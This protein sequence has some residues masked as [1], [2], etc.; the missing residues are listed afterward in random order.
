MI[1]LRP[2]LP[3]PAL[4]R[5][6]LLRPLLSRSIVLALTLA[7]FTPAAAAADYLPSFEQVQR[8]LRD[9]PELAAARAERD[10]AAHDADA[11]RHGPHEFETSVTPQQRRSAGNERFDEWEVQLSRP[12]RLPGKAALDGRIAAQMRDVAEQ[13]FL[14][15]RLAV[16]ETLLTQ[17]LQWL[18]AEHALRLLDTQQRLLERER[19]SVQVMHDKGSAATLDLDL[20]NADLASARARL[21]GAKADARQARQRLAKH[22]PQLLPPERAPDLADPR[23]AP[24][25][26][27]ALQQAL[28]GISA[29]LAV[30]RGQAAGQALTADRAN[31]ERRPD[32][33]LGLRWLRE[34]RDPEN[35]LG[36]V[37]SVPIGGGYRRAQAQAEA[38]REAAMHAQAQGVERDVELQAWEAIHLARSLQ[39]RWEAENAALAAHRSAADRSRRAWELGELGLGQYLIAERSLLDRQ[40][41]EHEA[42]M[43]ALTAALRVQLQ[44]GRLWRDPPAQP[45]G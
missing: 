21:I 34:G 6:A 24:E 38:A 39:T 20:I 35:A 23:P 25:D 18:A 43:A 9:H 16:Q 42:R 30:A 44:A 37:V 10:A 14:G 19:H 36:L 33:T 32:P 22:F 5:S 31:A 2:P 41:S 13:A 45:P 7:L 17:W 11:V 40:L 27:D 12:L 15:K 1:A 4:P 3:A 29:A 28:V 8:A 26:D